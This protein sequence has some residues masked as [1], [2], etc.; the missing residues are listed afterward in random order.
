[1]NTELWERRGLQEGGTRKTPLGVEWQAGVPT[2]CESNVGIRIVGWQ[3]LSLVHDSS[4]DTVFLW[5]RLAKDKEIPFNF[6]P[7][8]LVKRT[9]ALEGESVF[10]QALRTPPYRGKLEVW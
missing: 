2:A 7:W 8:L 3:A 9:R 6:E 10:W 4:E 5:H 1:M